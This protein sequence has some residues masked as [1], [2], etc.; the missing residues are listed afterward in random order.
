MTAEVL[1]GAGIP[2]DAARLLFRTQNTRRALMGRPEFV[3]DFVGLDS[4]A[5]RWLAEERPG[6]VRARAARGQP[7]A[8][9][10]GRGTTAGFDGPA[11]E[12]DS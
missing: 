7:R 3:T 12:A 4:S 5:A 2:R 8:R 1:Q 9:R 10:R 11:V 6:V